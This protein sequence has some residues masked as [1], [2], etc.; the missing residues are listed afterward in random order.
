MWTGCGLRSAFC[1]LIT[2]L[3]DMVDMVDMEGLLG[4]L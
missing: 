1:R 2:H 3:L 4:C